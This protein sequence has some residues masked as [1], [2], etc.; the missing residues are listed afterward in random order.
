MLPYNV[1]STHTNNITGVRVRLDGGRKSDFSKPSRET[2]D[3]ISAFY[4]RHVNLPKL[5]SLAAPLRIASVAGPTTNDLKS[6]LHSGRVKNMR[7]GGLGG[8]VFV[9]FP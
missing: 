2:G 1:F 7:F 6:A 8:L 5:Y 3:F 4:N 9:T